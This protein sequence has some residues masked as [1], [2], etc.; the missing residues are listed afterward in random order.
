M[1]RLLYTYI[2]ITTLRKNRDTNKARAVD[3][4]YKASNIGCRGQPLVPPPF[5]VARVRPRA[6]LARG[7]V[8]LLAAVSGATPLLLS[9]CS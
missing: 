6:A 7:A 1:K 4:G 3:T 5:L 9:T 2:Y 8:A